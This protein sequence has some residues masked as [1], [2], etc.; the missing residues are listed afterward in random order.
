MLRRR[1]GVH[2]LHQPL[3]HRLEHQPLRRRHLAQSREILAREHAQV[4]VRQQA[5]LERPFAVPGI[6]VVIA[7]I[8][9][10]EIQP[11]AFDL[12]I[13]CNA[14]FFTSPE[15][16]QRIFDRIYHGLRSEGVFVFNVMG[17]EDDATVACS[18]ERAV[19]YTEAEISNL[20]ECFA[21]EGMREVRWT[22]RD[23]QKFWHTWSVVLKK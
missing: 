1:A 12:V 2:R 4:R 20:S 8:E 11:G 10:Y 7:S 19:G 15:D 18:I 21:V 17:D 22:D 5:P 6:E 23:T 16:I 3:R 14:L 9:D 13:A